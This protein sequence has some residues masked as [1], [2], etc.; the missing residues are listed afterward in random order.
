MPTF[1]SPSNIQYLLTLI[2]YILHQYILHTAFREAPVSRAQKHGSSDTPT[3][4]IRRVTR[5]SGNS[6]ADDAQASTVL[7]DSMQPSTRGLLGA[8]QTS[9]ATAMCEQPETEPGTSTGFEASSADRPVTRALK[10]AVHSATAAGTAASRAGTKAGATPAVK[11]PLPPTASKAVTAQKAAQRERS[12]APQTAPAAKQSRSRQNAA[13]AEVAD[14]AATMGIGVDP[15]RPVTR[16][17]RQHMASGSDAAAAGVDAIEHEASDSKTRSK[18]ITTARAVPS[19][20]GADVAA[21]EAV[22]DESPSKTR[23]RSRSHGTALAAQDGDQLQLPSGGSAAKAPCTIGDGGV[24]SQAASGFKRK[25]ADAET[26]LPVP[27]SQGWCLYKL[28]TSSI[29]A[30]Y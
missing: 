5:Q 28:H 13:A 6:A 15:D 17:S 3:V 25:R 27:S 29:P 24:R 16:H 10:A 30:S 9:P 14:K 21:S 2:I 23:S 1:E 7:V 20:S 19:H 18:P 22:G 8:T 11:P 26:A 12:V 4:A